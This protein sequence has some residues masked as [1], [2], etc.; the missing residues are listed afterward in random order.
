MATQAELLAAAQAAALKTTISWAEYLR[1]I[2]D[3]EAYEYK[4]AA[5]YQ[6]GAQLEAL[7]H[8]PPPPPPSA[9]TPLSTAQGRFF[10]ADN[11][12]A[13]IDYPRWMVPVVTADPGYPQCQDP[14]VIRQLHDRFGTVEVWCDCMATPY[15]AALDLMHRLG[16]QGA[17]GQCETQ[18]QFDHAVG[19]GATRLVGKVDD[20]VLGDTSSK[21]A[22]LVAQGK[23]L[24]TV[25]LYSPDAPKDWRNLNAGI[26]GWCIATYNDADFP[27]PRQV[28]DYKA[29]GTYVAHRDSAYCGGGPKPSASQL[30]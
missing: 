19:A 16:L 17:W 30:G 14:E 8:L 1:R 15:Q 25:E 27:Q 23:V 6:A 29:N 10:L 9:P 21:R 3:N 24:V 13:C 7:K 11:P 5:W 12:L 2:D 20:S 22:Q 28:N 18:D 4:R 26:G